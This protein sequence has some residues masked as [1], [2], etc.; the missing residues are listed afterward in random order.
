MWSSCLA[1]LRPI[2]GDYQK[3][4]AGVAIRQLLLVSGGFSLVWLLRMA[5][6]GSA[7]PLWALIGALLAFDI[8]VAALDRF[9]GVF[10]ASRVS[11]PLF[12]NLR[13][14]SLEKVLAMPMEWHHA[15]NPV[16]F[17]SKLNNGAGKVV[18]T[19][20]IL[21]RELLPALIRTALSL[22]PLYGLVLSRRR[23]YWSVW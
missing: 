3:Y 21:G 6:P 8:G 2:Q 10:F 23:S 15:N 16:E 17:V 7:H 1:L 12:R 5:Q 19:A 20:E 13:I 18:Q 14:A 9:L 4:L 22:V 11:L